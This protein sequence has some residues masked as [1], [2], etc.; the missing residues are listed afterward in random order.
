MIFKF[1]RNL[2]ERVMRPQQPKI[3]SHKE[4]LEYR[5]AHNIT[6]KPITQKYQPNWEAIFSGRPQ[7]RRT[8]AVYK[9]LDELARDILPSYRK[10][11]KIILDRTGK[12]CSFSSISAW[13]KLSVL[14]AS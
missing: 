14:Y 8:V 10:I 13:K 11:L 3:T 9:I 4:A 7:Y 6:S 5:H 12:P 2:W 1:L